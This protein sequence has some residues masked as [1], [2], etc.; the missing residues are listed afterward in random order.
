MRDAL[1]LLSLLFTSILAWHPTGHFITARI[2]EIELSKKNPELYNKLIG[3]LAVLGTYTKEKNHPFVECA[4]FPDDIKYI[5]LKGFNQFHFYDYYILGDGAYKADMD[6]LAKSK[7]NMAA[8]IADSRETLRNIKKSQVDDHL[9]KSIML[10]YLIHLVGDVHQ[11]LHSTSRLTGAHKS[12][13]AGGN[14]FKLINPISDL[15]TKWD[16]T[17][18]FY[19]D[20]TAPLETN[21]WEKID[22]YSKKLM[23]AH[24][25]QDF[26]DKLAKISVTDWI[27]E[28]REIV[29]K[30]VYEGIED[31]GE[32]SLEYKR[33]AEPII[34]KQLVLGGYRLTDII[35]DT[36]S[37]VDLEAAFGD[38]RKIVK[39][40]K[41]KDEILEDDPNSPTKKQGSSDDD[42]GSTDSE[43]L[44]RKKKAGAKKESAKKAAPTK[45]A[46]NIIDKGVQ[47]NSKNNKKTPT[48]KQRD[49]VKNMN[50]VLSESETSSLEVNDPGKKTPA[51]KNR[52]PQGK[53][54]RF[55]EDDSYILN[56]GE[57]SEW[58]EQNEGE[59]AGSEDELNPKEDQPN[60]FVRFF[61][62][63]GR[64]FKNL[65]SSK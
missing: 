41:D 57:D 9:G 23:S 10:R 29:K 28:S 64:F 16:K 38:N 6:K 32:M 24:S 61:R 14:Q 53:K 17:L 36:Y 12:G 34:D 27:I 8:S 22:S 21:D 58:D 7:V 39:E 46:E 2:A 1:I 30:Y 54:K 25:R 33:I 18:G 3:L 48:K 55:S 37:K 19:K 4:C 65:F 35:I 11:P 52:F 13:D 31:G 51:K 50:L 59:K 40:E 26:G 43:K 45:R 5:G 47:T 56:E 49:A 20:T 62:A 63:I 44:S 42:V 15:H 60:V